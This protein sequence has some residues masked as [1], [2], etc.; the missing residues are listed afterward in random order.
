MLLPR[1]FKPLLLFLIC[2]GLFN[3]IA[4][5]SAQNLRSNENPNSAEN[6]TTQS[7]TIIK[8]S[9]Q[10]IN[11]PN[12]FVESLHLG[13]EDTKEKNRFRI[14]INENAKVTEEDV[15][16][17]LKSQIGFEKQ[18]F[19]YRR[20]KS[21][22]MVEGFYLISYRIS[23]DGY[24]V[25]DFR[26]QFSEKEGEIHKITG[27]FYQGLREFGDNIISKEEALEIL[28]NDV[29]KNNGHCFEI[30][31]FGSSGNNDQE[32]ID[33]VLLFI[34]QGILVYKFKYSAYCI[35]DRINKKSY[36]SIAEDIYIDVYSGEIIRR[37]N[38]ILNFAPLFIN[39]PICYKCDGT[40]TIN[41]VNTATLDCSD[42]YACGLCTGNSYGNL[43]DVS[44]LPSYQEYWGSNCLE[45]EF[46]SCDN[47]T[48]ISYVKND[49]K[50]VEAYT[51][52]ID[53]STLVPFCNSTNKFSEIESQAISAYKGIL[54]AK[55]Y[56]NSNFGTQSF[57]G[58][59]ISNGQSEEVCKLLIA[60]QITTNNGIASPPNARWNQNNFTFEFQGSDPS[61]DINNS[62]APIPLYS[63]PVD[64]DI[65]F[66][67][68]TH[69]F[70][71]NYIQ[72]GTEALDLNSRAI[73]EAIADIFAQIINSKPE[74]SN[75]DWI[76]GDENHYNYNGPNIGNNTFDPLKSHRNFIDPSLSLP[77]QGAN[78]Y[79]PGSSQEVQGNLLTDNWI[80]DWD[81]ILSDEQ[82]QYNRS[83]LLNFWF[84]LLTNGG[85][86]N[87]VNIGS[88]ISMA[89]SEKIMIETLNIIRDKVRLDTEGFN[90]LNS[91]VD[92]GSP[93]WTPDP[94]LY[95]GLIDFIEFRD[96]V[97]LAT[98]SEFP[99]ININ[100]ET[101]CSVEFTKV[102][103]AFEA[104]G[105][106]TPDNDA[107]VLDTDLNIDDFCSINLNIDDGSGI[108]F[109]LLADCYQGNDTY[110]LSYLS[111]GTAPYTVTF[112]ADA[113]TYQ[114][115]V[116]S[117]FTSSDVSDYLVLND[118]L[119]QFSN[120]NLT[121]TDY[122][123][124]TANLFGIEPCNNPATD[125]GPC[126]DF[127]FSNEEAPAFSNTNFDLLSTQNYCLGD[128]I[129]IDFQIS[130]NTEY[131]T[132]YATSI[133]FNGNELY[134][135]YDPNSSSAQDAINFC[136]DADLIQN[137]G[138]FINIQI[139]DNNPYQCSNNSSGYVN[140]SSYQYIPLNFLKTNFDQ[141]AYNTS[142]SQTDCNDNDLQ[143]GTVT[144]IENDFMQNCNYEIQI[145]GV[146][147]TNQ[148]HIGNLGLGTHNYTLVS[149]E[150]F[151][152]GLD[153]SYYDGSFTISSGNS[154]F[155]YSLN[156]TNCSGTCASTN[157]DG[158]I[159]LGIDPD[160]D[161][162]E[163]VWTCNDYQWYGK[164]NTTCSAIP[165]GETYITGVCPGIY[166]FEILDENGNCIS[167]ETFII[168]P[169]IFKG[170]DAI[171]GTLSSSSE[172]LKVYPNSYQ[173]Y[174]NIE[175]EAEDGIEIDIVV[176]DA[177]GNVVE[178]IINN[179]LYT[180]GK[181]TVTYNVGPEPA[182]L[183][184]IT[185]EKCAKTWGKIG[186]KF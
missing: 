15:W 95:K 97:L 14:F 158:T 63:A 1:N 162:D 85:A 38:M 90:E 182:G 151:A 115:T 109:Q 30:D 69:A 155:P 160:A 57:N 73:H 33:K 121:I 55:N 84:Y 6:T 172:Q 7:D 21:S 179:G 72:I 16:D 128:E 157:C 133:S 24:Y 18:K 129:C 156:T 60:Q 75:N 100:G 168:Y 59:D 64:K 78:Y 180:E 82:K 140:E 144:F 25:N 150:A 178:T 93:G 11:N 88:G 166:T 126:G 22:R 101:I 41:N 147:Y 163:I 49:N 5:V 111:G 26:L 31:F 61:Y 110:Y 94:Y 177:T 184:F 29:K 176:Y 136:F 114:Q 159:D 43:M 118:D 87:G 186:I 98:K 34:D 161:Y 142:G 173:T 42:L 8:G 12:E 117:D 56:F 148:N 89:S 107:D 149:M 91:N 112:V 96:Q 3:Q 35:I 70:L 134:N 77:V 175:F 124:A 153:D 9:W 120:L 99:D 74:F 108:E 164:F 135:N 48:N 32:I 104:V 13:L 154:S 67:E 125:A 66:H 171:G 53:P 141:V 83:Q 45:I 27:K 169:K 102:W 137:A 46:N 81:G 185:L 170:L 36:P 37:N 58:G 167:T 28:K 65:T 10:V 143:N 103:K 4:C 54:E 183:Y 139:T 44:E 122:N 2:L 40:T 165:N 51:F 19:S 145:D 80:T 71:H 47:N 130:E 152:I 76:Q 119:G 92:D 123:N 68:Y 127:S 79:D 131:H 138:N 132:P 17:I 174:T 20:T 106:I 62:D 23:F 39:I 105:L 116:I 146:Q 50:N 181:H 86:A 113:N 52:I